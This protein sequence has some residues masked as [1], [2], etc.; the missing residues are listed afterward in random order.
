MRMFVNTDPGLF[1]YS[2]SQI[3]LVNI[4]YFKFHTFKIGGLFKALH[5]I[6]KFRNCPNKKFLELSKLKRLQTTH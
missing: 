1:L 6:T 3:V 4:I 5:Q 2:E